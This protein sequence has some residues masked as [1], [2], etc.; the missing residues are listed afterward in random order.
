M[1]EVCTVSGRGGTV[2][3]NFEQRITLGTSIVAGSSS[4]NGSTTTPPAPFGEP[5]A[6]F[7]AS[8]GLAV[9]A[10]AANSAE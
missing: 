1:L 4:P 2:L 5:F 9:S 10:L 8:N 3:P 7:A 6:A